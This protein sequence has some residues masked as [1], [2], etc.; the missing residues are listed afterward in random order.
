MALVSDDLSL[1]DASARSLLDEVIQVGRA[2]DEVA[3]LG[4]P[5]VCDDLLEHRTPR[6]LSSAVATLSG[7]PDAGT[8]ELTP[9]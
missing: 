1:L 2:V 9:H 6:R 3:A 7:D 8:G 5:P 4:R